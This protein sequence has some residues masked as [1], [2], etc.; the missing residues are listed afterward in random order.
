MLNATTQIKR[1]MVTAAALAAI[2]APSAAAR[3]ADSQPVPASPSQSQPAT[4]APTMADS[5][6][7]KW[8]AYDK[9]WR[10][11]NPGT[12]IVEVP[13]PSKGGGLDFTSIILGASIPLTLLVVDAGGKRVLRRRREARVSHSLA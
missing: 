12:T 7:R 4:Q 1:T 9:G 10:A 5:V 3:P 8:E 11:A 13:G 6:T 2:A